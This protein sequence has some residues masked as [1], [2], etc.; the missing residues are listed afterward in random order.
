[1]LSPTLT[2]SHLQTRSRHWAAFFND[3]QRG[4]VELVDLGT[5]I[6]A[7]CNHRL[8]AVFLAR[9]LRADGFDAIARHGVVSARLPAEV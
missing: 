7:L 8:G 4:S 6:K 2:Y 5:A 1:M 3:H 9:N